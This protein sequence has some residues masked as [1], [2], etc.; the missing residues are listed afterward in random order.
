MSFTLSDIGFDVMIAE[1]LG[2]ETDPKYMEKHQKLWQESVVKP[3]TEWKKKTR[4]K[5]REKFLQDLGR[6]LDDDIIM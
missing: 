5:S 6:K 1:L 4:K 3:Y 2:E